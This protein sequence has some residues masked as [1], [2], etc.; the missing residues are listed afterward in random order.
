MRL[1][2]L[3]WYGVALAACA[4]GAV[5]GGDDLQCAGVWG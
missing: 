3:A 5:G 1:A 2:I 4:P